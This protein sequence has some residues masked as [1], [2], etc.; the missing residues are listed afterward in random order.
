[1][2]KNSMIGNQ[3]FPLLKKTQN[4]LPFF[5]GLK[6]ITFTGFLL[7][8]ESI[9]NNGSANLH[10]FTFNF[11]ER[12]SFDLRPCIIKQNHFKRTYEKEER[13][14]RFKLMSSKERQNLILKK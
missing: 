14:K 2:K 11:F 10:D 6:L 5:I 1:M 9:E 3:I 13:I 4:Y 8:N 7:H 12:V